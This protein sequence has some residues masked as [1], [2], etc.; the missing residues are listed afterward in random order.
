[1]VEVAYLAG[2]MLAACAKTNAQF[3]AGCGCMLGAA[4]AGTV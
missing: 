3:I 4:L 2:L 1:M